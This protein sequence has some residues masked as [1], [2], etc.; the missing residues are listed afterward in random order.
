MLGMFCKCKLNIDSLR[1]FSQII[2]LSVSFSSFPL[3]NS[4]FSPSL[5][6]I[7]SDDAGAE[8]VANSETARLKRG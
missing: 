8:A 2:C 1:V 4:A 7:L 6:L 5:H 3:P